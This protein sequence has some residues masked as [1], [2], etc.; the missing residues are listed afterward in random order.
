MTFEQ[1]WRKAMEHLVE[2]DWKVDYCEGCHESHVL[3]NNLC[4]DCRQ[5]GKR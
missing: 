1:A 5:E 4:F 3:I 2:N